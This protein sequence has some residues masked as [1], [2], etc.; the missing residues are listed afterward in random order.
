MDGIKI[1]K[2]WEKNRIEKVFML[3]AFANL[4]L[5]IIKF[6][7][8]FYF[9]SVSM[10]ADAL[11]S[12][13]DTFYSLIIL[14][15]SYFAYR[16]R[17]S[18]HPHGHERIRPFLSL[19]IAISVFLIGL[20]IVRG[21]INDIINDPSYQ[22]TK[23]FVI[24]LTISIITKLGLTK[25]LKAKSKELDSEVITSAAKD[26]QADVLASTSALI[27]IIGARLGYLYLDS[28]FGLLVSIWIFRTAYEMLKENFNYLTGASPDQEI[29]DNIKEQIQKQ[30]IGNIKDLE[31]HYVGPKLHVACEIR[32]S[33]D[34][35]LKEAH[36]REEEIKNNVETI[37]EVDTAYIHI[38][39]YQ[40]T[41]N[42]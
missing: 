17:D 19:V 3:L 1:K 39:P 28:I 25:Y 38:E 21:A 12:L 13:G 31:A 15:G 18:S 34:L 27:G 5:F 29:W 9:N 7:P 24:S 2:D 10:R 6:I 8:S 20:T 26:S 40:R 36:E 41:E 4:G 42:D 37:N 16:E 23:Y 14:I 11:N 33:G 30:N 22:F 32:L 35:T